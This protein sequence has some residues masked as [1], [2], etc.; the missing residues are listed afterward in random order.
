MHRVPLERVVVARV[1]TVERRLEQGSDGLLRPGE[2]VTVRE[3]S[4]GDPSSVTVVDPA[5][6]SP[7]FRVPPPIVFVPGEPLR[8]LSSF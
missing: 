8:S 1:R 5:S 3:S 6:L 2:I 7:I 4:S